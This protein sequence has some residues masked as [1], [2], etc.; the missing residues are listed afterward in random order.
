MTKKHLHLRQRSIHHDRHSF[1]LLY[2]VVTCLLLLGLFGS[3]WAQE[4]QC[5]SFAPPAVMKGNKIFV[6]TTG[7]YLPIK[8]INYYPRPNAYVP[9]YVVPHTWYSTVYT[10][11]FLL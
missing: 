3:A 8:G 4:Q 10:C 11:G 9:I 1:P 5:A 6:S 2:V 7:D